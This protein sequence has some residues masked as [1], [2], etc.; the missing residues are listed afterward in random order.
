MRR[1]G[2]WILLG[3]V[4]LAAAVVLL[5]GFPLTGKVKIPTAKVRKG[6]FLISL[7]ATGE[8][9]AKRAYTVVA[10][11]I[12][13]IQ[14]TWMAPEGSMVKAGDAV[15]RF[16]SSQQQ[17]DLAENQS[18]LQISQTA[19]QRQKTEYEIQQ[20]ELSLELRRAQRAYD[21]QKHEAPK[22]AEEAR[23]ALELAELNAKAK[24]DQIEADI[25]KAEL[26]VQRAEDKV[27]LAQKE[28]DQMTLTAP[29]PGMVVYLE[30]W[31][32][33]TMGK[34]Q[35][36]DSPWPGQG[37][38]NLPDLGEMIVNATVS[39]VDASRV[40]AGQEALVTLDAFPDVRFQGKVTRKGT[41]ARRKEPD[42]KINVFD[43]E[44]AIDD[45]DERLKPGMSASAPVSYTHLTLPT[46][47]E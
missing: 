36:G 32:G 31:K 29:I 10:P 35:E 34:V 6:D 2:L 26:E 18:S 44:I 21:E 22:V 45:V 9:Q 39:E 19:L 16:D 25:R 8:V 46:S 3:T 7:K 42:S 23:L 17:A 13:N 38:I 12:R 1:R 4:L 11:R 37:L 28:L 41:L 20:K 47:S 15:I 14:I 33:S 30:I 43:V 5:S 24:L 27:D 40:D